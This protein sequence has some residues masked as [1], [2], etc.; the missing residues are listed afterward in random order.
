MVHIMLE[1]KIIYQLL[2][3]MVNKFILV[4]PLAVGVDV[5]HIQ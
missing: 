4:Y 5:L 2:T 1:E 3:Y